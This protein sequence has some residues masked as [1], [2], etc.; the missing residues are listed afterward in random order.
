MVM[1]ESGN[2]ASC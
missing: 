2:S 1:T